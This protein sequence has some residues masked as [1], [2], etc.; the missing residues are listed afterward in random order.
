MNTYGNFWLYQ[1]LNSKILRSK[2]YNNSS[3]FII[4]YSLKNTG[5]DTYD[6]TEK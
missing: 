2:I 6:T 3:I 1:K 4:N 5:G